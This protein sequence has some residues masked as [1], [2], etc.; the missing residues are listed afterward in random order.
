MHFSDMRSL[1][2]NSYEVKVNSSTSCFK[3]REFESRHHILDGHFLH[4]FV[5]KILM[6]VWKDKN[7]WKRGWGWPIFKKST[8]SCIMKEGCVLS[9]SMH[10]GQINVWPFESHFHFHK[11]KNLTDRVT[12]RLD[13]ICQLILLNSVKINKI[14]PNKR[15]EI[16]QSAQ[17][18]ES[19]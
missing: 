4:L 13:A 3:G 11:K 16:C 1:I 9:A 19:E 17:I 6:C 5:V 15:P 7:K 10:S 18:L 8:S 12:W 2:W 14:L